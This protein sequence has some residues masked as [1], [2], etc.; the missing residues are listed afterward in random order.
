MADEMKRVFPEVE[1]ASG[2]GW[3]N[4]NSFSLGDK[5]I[6]EQGGWAG[7]DYFKMF[8]YP[9]LLGDAQT[10]L[11]SPSAIAVSKKMAESF[12]V[13]QKTRSIKPFVSTIKEISK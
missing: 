5:V 7:D 12:F 3:I 4:E 1:Y 11:N 8:G 13:A 6:E 9:L 10:A 2:F